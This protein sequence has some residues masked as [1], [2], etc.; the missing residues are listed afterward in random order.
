MANNRYSKGATSWLGVVGVGQK[1][2]PPHFADDPNLQHPEITL[3]ALFVFGTQFSYHPPAQRALAVTHVQYTNRL[4]M[5]DLARNICEMDLMNESVFITDELLEELGITPEP[6][7]RRSFN[8]RTW[9]MP[10][11]DF[12]DV[13]K[14]RETRRKDRWWF[15]TF[16]HENG[17]FDYAIIT[18]GISASD[19][20][21]RANELG[22]FKQHNPRWKALDIPKDLLPRI[23]EHARNVVLTIERVRQIWSGE[24]REKSSTQ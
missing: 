11:G 24:A 18:E 3:V 19:A 22:F 16:E 10:V 17:D 23:P 8:T 21:M 5:D 4:L 20:S 7:W 14:M 1:A 15:V 12:Q 13:I 2:D 6:H 9:Y